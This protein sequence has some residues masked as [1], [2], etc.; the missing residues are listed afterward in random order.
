[1]ITESF[2]AITTLTELLEWRAAHSPDEVAFIVDDKTY[3]YAWL[4]EKSQSFAALLMNE[5]VRKKDRVV[6]LIPNSA[7][8]FVAFYGCILSGAIVVPVF[9]N[10]GTERC[11]QMLKLCGGNHVILPEGISDER[12]DKFTY[13]AE[14]TGKHIHW[15]SASAPKTESA[16]YPT[17]SS[18]DIAFIQYTSGSTDFPKGVPLTH[19]NLLSNIRQMVE[20]MDINSSDTFVSWLPV[21]HDMGLILNTMVPFYTGAGLVLLAEGLHKVHSW[22]NAI[23]KYKGTFL[24]APDI[25]Y[26]LC[27]KSIRRPEDYDLSSLRV[28]LNASERIQFETYQMFEETFNLKNV[29]ASGYGLAEATVAVTMHPP[30]KP[31]VIDSDGYVASGVPLKGIDIKIDTKS[32]ESGSQ[33]QG[34]ILVKSN[35]LMMGYYNKNKGVHPFDAEGYL[36]TG[37][38]GYLDPND[39]L[40]VLARKK[41]CIKHAGHTIYPDDIEQVVKSVGDI[42]NVMAIGIDSH[43]G[44]GESLYVFAEYRSRHRDVVENCHEVAVEIVQ[45][46]NA[47]FGIKPG[48]IFIVKPKTLPR[49]PNGKLQHSSLKNTYLNN[50]QVLSKDI[51]YPRNSLD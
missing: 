30:G 6:I 25:A 19:H 37:D 16:H 4:L 45:K 15:V 50:F 24:A 41:N 31:P 20:A 46:I 44:N 5:N 29:M 21:Y 13:W 36:R 18:D 1:M 39:N 47:H 40:F 8:F 12:K 48:R 2:S 10:A 28:A 51:L 38:I 7:A 27:V 32:L 22:L 42:R 49:T 35:S 33:N 17:I 3:S 9:P 26:R 43:I 34:E 23:Q 11:E 14:E